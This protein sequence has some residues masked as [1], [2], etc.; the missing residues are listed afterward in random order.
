MDGVDGP[1]Y[2]TTVTITFMQNGPV[3]RCTNVQSSKSF[4]NNKHLGD[5]IA[6]PVY[7]ALTQHPETNIFYALVRGLGRDGG[8]KGGL[9]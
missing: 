1:K 8:I 4:A 9:R 5:R 2:S 7:Q 3:K 6:C